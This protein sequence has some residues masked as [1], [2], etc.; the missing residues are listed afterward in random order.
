VKVLLDTDIT[1]YI[2]AHHD[3][4]VRRRFLAFAIGD[5]GISTITVA[6]LAFG[7]ELNRSERNRRAIER[8]LESLAIMPF[9]LAAARAYGQVR[10]ALQRRGTPIGPL[11]MLIAAHAISLDVP[12][13]TNNVR[14][15]RRVPG[16]RI[17]NWLS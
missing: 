1:S 4:R 6:E 15:F 9:E 8:A 12:L 7:S 10:T 2:F 17:E 11:D 14:E 16:L 3:E 5:V 13:V